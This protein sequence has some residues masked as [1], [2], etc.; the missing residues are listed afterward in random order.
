MRLEFALLIL[1]MLTGCGSGSDAGRVFVSSSGHPADWVNPLFIG[2]DDFHGTRIRNLRDGPED[3]VLFVRHCSACHGANAEGKIGPS[4]RGDTI[5]LINTAIG[6]FPIM[7]GHAVLSQEERQSIAD[8]LSSPGANLP[9]VEFVFD[10]SLCMECHGTD[11]DGG[12][13]EVSCFACHNGPDGSVGHP[14]GWLS[15]IDDPAHFHGRYG[16]RFVVSCTNC[17]GFDLRGRI[18]PPCSSCHD[19]TTAPVLEPFSL[20]D[21]AT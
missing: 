17:H 5:D 1:L 18:G 21:A 8:Y 14:A 6:S 4:I 16:K 15:R 13:A 7:R 12:I 9:A 10:T 19:G 11:L 2:R 3:G 20:N